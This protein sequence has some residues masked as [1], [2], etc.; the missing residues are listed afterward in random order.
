MTPQSNLNVA[1]ARRAVGAAALV[2]SLAPAAGLANPYECLI[3][4]SQVVEVRSPVEGLIER[5]HV[6]RGDRVRAGQVLVQLESAPE[7]SALEMA[8]YR[9]AMEG[10][11]ASAKNRLEF[12]SKKAAR[13]QELKEQNFLTA[14]ARDEAEAE[15]RVAESE[16]RDAV[17]NRELA[18]HE[19]RHSADLLSRRTLR[20]PFNGVVVDRML[21]PGDLAESGT[22]RKPIMKIAQVEPLRVEVVLP[23][24]AFGKIKVGSAAQVV[25]EAIGGRHPAKVLLVDSVFD[26]ASG[27][28][29]VRLEIANPLGELPAGIRCQVEFTDAKGLPPRGPKPK[30]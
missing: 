21:N 18:R 15:R 5:V 14:Q 17:E 23:I 3:E 11:V 1:S 27:T 19:A 7:A 2:L 24:S 6:K 29:G 20:S 10:R 26:S 28:F 9:S 4:A 8:K 13:A 16:L 25:P 12:A 22:G 30:L